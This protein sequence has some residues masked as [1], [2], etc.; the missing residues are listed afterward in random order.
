[1]QPKT[2]ESCDLVGSSDTHLIKGL[3]ISKLHDTQ[4]S[5]N[6]ALGSWQYRIP[7]WYLISYYC[8]KKLLKRENNIGMSFINFNVLGIMGTCWNGRPH[9]YNFIGQSLHLI[10]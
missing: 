2:E 10:S 7:T 4:N 9:L 1:M 5:G 6:L 8:P 3:G